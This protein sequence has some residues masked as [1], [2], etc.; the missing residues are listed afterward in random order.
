MK[1]PKL[2]SPL[3]KASCLV[4]SARR[5]SKD[6]PRLIKKIRSGP[7]RSQQLLLQL[8]LLLFVGLP[9]PFFSL[10]DRPRSSFVGERVQGL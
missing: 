5:C 8:I 3:R 2:V 10:R 4:E 1:I 9:S 6:D 7:T